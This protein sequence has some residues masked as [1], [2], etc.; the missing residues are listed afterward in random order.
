MQVIDTPAMRPATLDAFLTLIGPERAG[1]LRDAARRL[2]GGLDGGTL[3][4]VNSTATGGG[5]AEMLY[6]LVPLYRALGVPTRWAVV[7]GDTAFFDITKRL[8]NLAYG[9]TADADLL[10]PGDLEGYT[11][12]LAGEAEELR[13]VLRPGDVLLLHDHQ[14][15]GLVP[16]LSAETAGIYWRCHVGVDEPTDGSRRAWAA[17]APL[18]DKANGVIFSVAAHLPAELSGHRVAIIPP[19]L[20]PFAPKNQHLP[21]GQLPGLLDRCGLGGPGTV[22]GYVLADGHRDPA[23]PLVVQVSRWDRLKDMHAVLTGFGAVPDAQLALIGP[24]PASIPDDIEQA[25]WFD[26][27]RTTWTALPDRLRHRTRLVCLPMHDLDDN[28]RLVNAAQRAA[29]VVVQKSLAEGFGLTVTEAMWKA[30]PVVGSAVGG[31]AAQIEHG[32]T[33][34]LLDDPHDL[35]AFAALVTRLTS[36]ATDGAALGRRARAR[37]HD[38]YLPD[39]DLRA[40]TGLLCA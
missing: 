30:R 3:W 4:H 37:V 20:W 11:G 23:E 24:D 12:H 6:V 39:T 35:A 29:D 2:R 34:L 1:R 9:S 8:G 17:L 36:G 27:C 33:G 25:H 32:A 10:R 18:L 15:A 21:A 31:I 16:L 19:V 40:V 26:V 13:A 38:A 5:V 7:D 28:A 14:T 22:P